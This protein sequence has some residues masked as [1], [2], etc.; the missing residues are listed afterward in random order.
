[1]TYFEWNI[2]N[3]VRHPLGVGLGATSGQFVYMRVTG[4]SS[5]SELIGGGG[6]ESGFANVALELGVLGLILLLWFFVRIIKH[7][8]RAFY[9]LT[10]PFL[11]WLA[12]AIVVFITL[13]ALGNVV[14]PIMEVFPAGDLYFWFLLGLLVRLESVQKQEALNLS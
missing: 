5:E 11:K 2:P 14:G 1:M 8:L 3:I 6:T 10:D 12:A 13:I 7:G 4:G 9:R